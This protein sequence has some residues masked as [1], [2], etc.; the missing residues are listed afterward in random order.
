MRVASIPCHS[1][2]RACSLIREVGSYADLIELRLDYLKEFCVHALQPVW[3]AVSSPVILTWRKF[4]HGGH[5]YLEE[6]ERLKRLALLV[7]RYSPAY[8]DIEYDSDREWMTALHQKF[9]QTRLI[10]SYHNFRETPHD[11]KGLLRRVDHP[12]FDKVKI[13]TWAHEVED[14][15]R[16][17]L[18]LKQT[19]SQRQLIGLAMGEAGEASRMIAP[20]MGS[21]FTYGALTQELATSPGQFTLKEMTDIYRVASFTPETEI[22]ALIGDPIAQ[23]PGHIFHNAF[24]RDHARN[25]VYIKLKISPSTLANSMALLKQMNAFKGLSVTIP[26][27]EKMP[28][29]VDG[30]VGDAAETGIINTVKLEKGHYIGYNTDGLGS[31]EVLNKPLK[32]GRS[33]ILILGAGGAGKAIAY[34]LSRVGGE[35]TLCNR[36]FHPASLFASHHGL[37]LINF[38]TLKEEKFRASKSFQV[39]INTLPSKV[40]EQVAANWEIPPAEDEHC[41]A[42]D[43]TLDPLE[44]YF[45]QKAKAAGYKGILGDQ[46]FKAQADLQL[47]IWFRN[48]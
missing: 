45:L 41:V 48:S 10:G 12:L 32:T 13:A 15:L 16:L 2:E 26:H 25:A 39:I 44:T 11:L 3:A 18:F 42:M 43:I 7:E 20:I 47:K 23:S 8:L 19:S 27:K 31:V 21:R 36:T 1:V 37:S 9:P 30:L 34:A 33:T 29:Y 46:L 6:K 5:A 4:S 22:Y 24:F 40:F 14:A 17:C 35:V 28:L 38:Q